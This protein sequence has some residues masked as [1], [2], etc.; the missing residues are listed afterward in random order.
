MR[1]INDNKDVELELVRLLFATKGPAAA[2]AELADRIKA[3]GDI[4]TFQMAMAE[5]DYGQHDYDDSFK[6]LRQLAADTSAADHALAAKIELAQFYLDQKNTDQAEKLIGE[7]LSTDG[8][9]V[10]ALKLRAT[11]E[12]NRDQLDLA[13]NDL[14]AALNDQPRDTGLMLLMATAYERS[15]SMELAEKQLTDALQVSKYDTNVA[16][17]YVSFLQRRGNPQRAEDVLTDMVTR[18]PNDVQISLHSRKPRWRGRIGRAS[19]KSARK[20]KASAAPMA[21]PTRSWAQPTA[22]RTRSTKALSPFRML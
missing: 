11:I 6:L 18:K 13:I 20:S 5:L 9:N 3:G 1:S 7:I 2:K 21:W 15:G 22:A 17:S 10:G 4:F 12:L 19:R 16:L 14:R 8:R